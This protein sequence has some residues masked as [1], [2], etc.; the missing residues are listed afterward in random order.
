V[1]RIALV[2]LCLAQLLDAID[3]TV[4]NVA[5]PTIKEQLGFS[6]ANLAWVVNAYTVLFGGFLL[7]GGGP[8]ILWPPQGV[9]RRLAWIRHRDN[10]PGFG[11]QPS[12][13]G[14]VGGIRR[15]DDARDGCRVRHRAG[16]GAQDR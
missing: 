4:V 12:G 7:L 3:I 16:A 14:P 10:R 11:H 2:V 6:Q 5:L 9:H 15:P 13:A 8:A 1:H